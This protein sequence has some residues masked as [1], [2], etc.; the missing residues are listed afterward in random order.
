MPLSKVILRLNATWTK[1]SPGALLLQR[2]PQAFC[3]GT[4]IHTESAVVK[5]SL[6]T[7]WTEETTPL[8]TLSLCKG[9]AKTQVTSSAQCAHFTMNFYIGSQDY[10]WEDTDIRASS[11]ILYQCTLW[12]YILQRHKRS[13]W[14]D[15]SKPTAC[16]FP[17]TSSQ[18]PGLKSYNN[19]HKHFHPN[20]KTELKPHSAFLGRSACYYRK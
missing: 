5:V 20:N 8:V 9:K 3:V 2:D 13:C 15:D 18:M 19:A 6:P 12:G 10:Q 17:G 16:K 7:Y 11:K 14:D 1:S 4:L